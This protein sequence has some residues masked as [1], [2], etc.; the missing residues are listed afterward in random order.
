MT[1]LVEE[2]LAHNH[3]RKSRTPKIS[4]VI[5]APSGGWWGIRAGRD[6]RPRGGYRVLTIGGQYADFALDATMGMKIAEIVDAVAP[7]PVL[8][9]MELLAPD[10]QRELVAAFAERLRTRQARHPVHVVLDESEDFCQ[11]NPCR[12]APMRVA[13]SL[14]YLAGHGRNRGISVTVSTSRLAVLT[15]NVSS[16]AER[17]FVLRMWAPQ[18][19]KAA[20]EL[21]SYAAPLEKRAFG[22]SVAAL[23]QGEAI[24]VVYGRHYGHSRF[25]VRSGRTF[26]SRSVPSIERGGK[27]RPELART[28]KKVRKIAGRIMFRLRDP[29]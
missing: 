9:Q 1:V 18:D 4:I 15:G 19:L 7:S 20:G 22:R 27:T 10:E 17:F 26:N 23:R 5:L 14:S 13:Q 21:I 28:S 24:H 11:S 29:Q 16:Q 2:L 8:V 25:R 12:G 6:G 3:R